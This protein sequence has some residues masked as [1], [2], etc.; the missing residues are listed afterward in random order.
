MKKIGIITIQG[1]NYGAT[2]Q[3]V[4]LNKI[5]NSMG[6]S[7]E[8]LNYNDLSRIR[9]GLSTPQRIRNI[10]WNVLKS[11]ITGNA[12]N[13]AFNT[14]RKR[15]LILSLKS[16]TSQDSLKKNPPEYDLYIS[17]SDQ[18]WNPDVINGDYNYLLDFVPPGK[19]KASYASSFG[20]NS[21]PKQHT[22]I[23]RRLLSN[24]Q[25]LSVREASGKELIRQLTGKDAQV[26]LDPTLLLGSSQWEKMASNVKEKEKYILCYYMPGDKVVNKAIRKASLTLAKRTD[27]HIVNLG[28]KEYF[29]LV[30][31]LDCRIKAGPDD[32][33]RLFLDAEY[34]VT[35]SFHGAAFAVNFGKRLFVP[36]NGR[37]AEGEALHT[38]LTEFLK[39][40]HREQSMW[41]VTKQDNH[42][43]LFESQEAQL[44]ESLRILE[45]LKADSLQYLASIINGV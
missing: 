13:N 24:Y 23:Y 5:I 12:R 32:F 41:I 9:R 27:L 33:I 39:M 7:V 3:A 25:Y 19:V 4:A 31:W 17:G 38:R 10:L 28:L 45:I 11:F 43:V 34:I 36:V 40:M 29:G 30:P 22:E 15:H 21:I 1:D 6:Y 35:N 8:N 14:F 42:D 20:K 37:I 44:E 16:W 2:L 26:V 18:I